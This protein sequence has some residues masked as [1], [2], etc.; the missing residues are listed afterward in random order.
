[1]LLPPGSEK[2][3]LALLDFGLLS[4][5]SEGDRGAFFGGID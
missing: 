2:G 5:I 4:T 3:E 1:M